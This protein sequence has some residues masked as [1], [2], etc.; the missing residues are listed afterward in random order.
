MPQNRRQ[1]HS[2]R[3]RRPAA[4]GQGSR[5]PRPGGTRRPGPPVPPPASGA[6][7][8]LEH[9]SYPILVRLTSTPK[10]VLGVVTGAIL[11]GGLL[12]P[13]PWGPALLGVVVLFLAWLLT[14]AWPR[15]DAGPKTVRLVIVA[16]MTALVV[17]RAAGWIA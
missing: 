16:A 6:R 12:A 10:W 4:P 2:N 13:P 9:V 3:N 15:L 5:A 7:A 17:S 8:R 14:L 11:L 1:S